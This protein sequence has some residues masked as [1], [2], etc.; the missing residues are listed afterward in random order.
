MPAAVR[1][2]DCKMLETIGEAQDD[3]EGVV[4]HTILMKAS[5]RTC[6]Y[7]VNVLGDPRHRMVCR[8]MTYFGTSV[9]FLPRLGSTNFPLTD[10]P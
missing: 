8:G 4:F 5:L 9:E 3:E 6:L 2:P 10:L 7:A 1:Y